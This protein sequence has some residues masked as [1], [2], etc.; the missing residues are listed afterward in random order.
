MRTDTIE[1]V[2]IDGGGSLWVKPTSAT[3]PLIYRE[4]MEVHWD[5]ERLRLYSPKPREWSYGVW[6]K[7][8]RDAAREQGVEL[9]LGPSTT[10]SGV[11]P[12]L[13]QT[14]KADSGS[15]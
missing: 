4:A 13:Q 9:Q 1:A 5:A 3:F 10:W 15:A 11:D 6:F 12:E 8:I 7:Q 2:G 14:M